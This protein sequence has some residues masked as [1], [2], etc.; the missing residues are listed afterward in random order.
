LIHAGLIAEYIESV[1]GT[2]FLMLFIA[3]QGL[4]I[5]LYFLVENPL[6]KG[7]RKLLLA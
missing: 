6:N 5:G 4:S 3:L 7:I 2:N 1:I